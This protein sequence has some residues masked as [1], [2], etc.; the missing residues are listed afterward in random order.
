MATQVLLIHPQLAFIVTLKHTLERSGAYEVHPFTNVDAALEYLRDHPQDVALVDVGAPGRSLATVIPALRAIQPRLAVIATPEQDDDA[1][2]ES[3]IQGSI[4]PPFTAR[5]LIPYISR[6]IAY[7]RDLPQTGDL[8]RSSPSLKTRLLQ[9]LPQT[10]AADTGSF[11]TPVS[12]SLSSGPAAPAPPQPGDLPEFSSLDSVLNMFNPSELFEPDYDDGD[13]P[14]LEAPDLSGA[15]MMDAVINQLRPDAGSETGPGASDRFLDLVNSM[16]DEKPH[17]PLPERT[18]PFVE[19]ILTGGMDNLMQEIEV[20][21]TG[22]LPALEKLRAEEPA[23]PTFEESGTIHDLMTGVEDTGFR[24]VLAILRGDDA[25]K[26]PTPTPK[27]AEPPRQPQPPAGNSERPAPPQPSDLP[28]DPARGILNTSELE[29]FIDDGALNEPH[30]EDDDSPARMILEHALDTTVPVNSHTISE[31]INSI[32]EQ[33]PL[34]KPNVL[35]LPSWTR[36]GEQLEWQTDQQTASQRVSPSW[37]DQDSGVQ[38]P[39]FLPEFPDYDQTTRSIHSTRPDAAAL[40]TEWIEV[41]PRPTLIPEEQLPPPAPAPEEPVEPQQVVISHEPMDLEELVIGDL[42]EMVDTGVS[43]AEAALFGIDLDSFEAVE[44]WADDSARAVELVTHD[45]QAFETALFDTQFDRLAAFDLAAQ[46]TEDDLPPAEDDRL[47]QLALSLT[48]V[49][50]ELSAEATLLTRQG[51]IIA[52]AGTGLL[53]EDIDEVRSAI[54]D[55]WEAAVDQVR[56]RF[57]RL[58]DDG[59]DYLLYSRRTDD[60][61]TL[62]LVFVGD[63][64]LRDVSRQCRR[65]LKALHDVPVPDIDESMVEEVEALAE[66]QAIIPVEPALDMTVP[67][68]PYAFVWLLREATG[69]FSD[70]LANALQAGLRAQLRQLG[71]AIEAL[72]VQE[73]FVYLLADVPGEDLPHD[74]IRELKRRASEIAAAQ[75]SPL[76]GPALWSDSYL[77]VSPGRPLELDEIQQFIDFDRTAI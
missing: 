30:P 33:I 67:R 13:T 8:T 64:P 51:E 46:Q 42:A 35:P 58:G 5:D 12:E 75:G 76:V 69:R 18:Q 37:E 43:T 74:L 53:P 54:D 45:T 20:N 52:F 38:E 6:A 10:D 15:E 40:E 1:A 49:S 39:D 56:M 25:D 22:E 73:D 28:E 21:R 36:E 17:K 29:V 70:I 19:F 47:A 48:Q 16:R 11:D 68:A 66:S 62:S 2:R 32:E 61:Y 3:A 9:P 71:W 72:V 34:H 23:A 14:S 57:I 60:G 24:N 63:T 44:P 65:L 31:L 27:T 4:T 50:L 59:K 26:L 7:T 55:D 41:P 77:V